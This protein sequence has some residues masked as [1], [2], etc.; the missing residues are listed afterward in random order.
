MSP[1]AIVGMISNFTIT[2]LE[3]GEEQTKQIPLTDIS[4]FQYVSTGEQGEGQGDAQGQGDAHTRSNKNLGYLNLETNVRIIR[5]NLRSIAW[6]VS[7]LFA[8]CEMWI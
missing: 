4:W 7:F 8:T 2:F 6:E 5:S 1:C 3:N